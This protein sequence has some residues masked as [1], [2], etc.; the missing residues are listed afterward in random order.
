M[1]LWRR[2]GRR[3]LP[4]P[5]GSFNLS[6]GQKVHTRE[7]V[8]QIRSNLCKII[9]RQIYGVG[10]VGKSKSLGRNAP[11]ELEL[12]DGASDEVVRSH[13]LLNPKGADHREHI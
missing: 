3:P 7:L 8:L 11:R 12:R 2:P 6:L 4:I 10:V 5:N 9:H 1:L 13:R